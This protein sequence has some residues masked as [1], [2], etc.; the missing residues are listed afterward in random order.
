MRNKIFYTFFS[1]LLSVGLSAQD[2]T[3]TSGKSLTLSPGAYIIIPGNL[4]NEGTVNLT[5]SSTEY[6]QMK[7]S[8]SASGNGTVVQSQYLES[9]SH[10]ISSPFT[11][12]FTT[13]TSGDNTKLYP[14][15]ATA[16]NWATIGS[17]ATTAGVGYAARVDAAQIPFLTSAGLVSVTGTPNTSMTHTLGYYGSNSL[18][19]GSGAGWNLLGNPYTCGL[20]WAQV[21]LTNIN[22]A[23]YIW[24]PST[25]AYKYYSGGGIGSS[26][27]P[28]MQAF[29]VQATQSGTSLTTNMATHGTVSSSPTYYKTMPDNLVV[30]VTKPSDTAITDRLWVANISGT[31]DGF[32]GA[33]DAWKMTN[34][35]LMP[36]VYTYVDAEGIAIN[37]IEI[38]GSKVLPMG[39]DYIDLGTKF[40]VNLEQVTNGQV[41]DV[42]LEDKLLHAFHDLS[43]GDYLFTHTAWALE[44]PRF[45]LH[46]SQSTIGTDEPDQASSFMA[47]QDHDRIVL[48]CLNC[49]FTAYRL[50][51]LNG[52]E[53]ARGDLDGGMQSIAAPQTAGLYII[54]LTGPQVA[55]REKISIVR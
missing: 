37:A 35:P 42:Y 53:I 24:D 51:G 36:N 14:Y 8:G 25:S 9:G 17:S 12:G 2:L 47:Y 1:L 38:Q 55:A 39:F 45:A 22:N 19:G 44:E 41:Y 29:W 16:G 43:Q 28:P 20:D 52:Q 6:S 10:L 33:Y 46:F 18:A 21:S 32:D 48:N 30:T 40:K 50:I 4:S 13:L 54:E 49:V 7:V 5:A 11:Q 15:D 34:G 23:F 26:I 3:I 27:I 31:Q